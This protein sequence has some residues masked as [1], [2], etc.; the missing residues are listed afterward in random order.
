[1]SS[2][3]TTTE[4]VGHEPTQQLVLLA[5]PE[6]AAGLATSSAPARFRLSAETRRRGL[7]HVAEIRRQLAESRERRDGERRH[8]TAR[9]ADTSAAGT[10]VGAVP[11]HAA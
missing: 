11:P 10:D 4:H 7:E 6:G 3:A 2:T 8:L 9:A 5:V 1:M